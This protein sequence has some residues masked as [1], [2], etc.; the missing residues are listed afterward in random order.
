[1]NYCKHNIDESTCSYCNGVYDKAVQERQSKQHEKEEDTET[2]IEYEKLKCKF[3]NL[4]EDWEEDE[5]QILHTQLK[6]F[7]YKSS[8][9]RRAVYQVAITLGRTRKSIVWHYKHLF[10]LPDHSKAGKNLLEFKR[11]LKL[12]V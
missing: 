12:E 2:R 9:W 6:D 3:E 7:K 5:Y 10:I 4:G 8:K 11:K 1:M